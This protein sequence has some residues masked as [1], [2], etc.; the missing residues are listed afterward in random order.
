M[1]DKTTHLLPSQTSALRIIA[2]LLHTASP[3]TLRA[4]G[5]NIIQ[6]IDSPDQNIPRQ[7][8]ELGQKLYDAIATLC[9]DDSRQAATMA[10][11]TVTKDGLS[12]A[13]VLVSL[14]PIN[15]LG[16]NG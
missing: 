3:D 1:D 12:Q 2:Q 8:M 10:F 13:H 9:A 5:E 15:V 16:S 14:K 4:V 7:I 11:D 6:A